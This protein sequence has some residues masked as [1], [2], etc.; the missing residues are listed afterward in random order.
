MHSAR[1]FSV[2]LVLSGLSTRADLSEL[3]VFSEDVDHLTMRSYL[4]T[5]WSAETVRATDESRDTVIAMTASSGVS[6]ENRKR[7]NRIHWFQHAASPS[8]TS[9]NLGL[10]STSASCGPRKPT[11][12]HYRFR[13]HKAIEAATGSIRVGACAGKDA[14]P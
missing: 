12:R 11:S 8:I 13:M 9:P 5:R 1:R 10:P 14:R 7:E 2:F 6:A 4:P 3:L